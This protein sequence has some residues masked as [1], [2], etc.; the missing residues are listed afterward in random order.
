M[1]HEIYNAL[2]ARI[3]I[4][5]FTEEDKK[6]YETMGWE[7]HPGTIRYHLRLDDLGEDFYNIVAE[8]RTKNIWNASQRFWGVLGNEDLEN[9]LLN[10]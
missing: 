2:K 9:A 8:M 10:R 4:V 5:P 6:Y 3:S 1:T 7:H